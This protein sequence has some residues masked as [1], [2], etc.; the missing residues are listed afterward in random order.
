MEKL[1][2]LSVETNSEREVG[3]DRNEMNLEL[4][5][6]SEEAI[7]LGSRS[8]NR[9]LMYSSGTIS[10]LSWSTMSINTGSNEEES[11]RFSDLPLMH[12]RSCFSGIGD[13]EKST[14][15]HQVYL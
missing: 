4:E 1:L 7:K 13:L 10:E 2:E 14:L 6:N 3:V 15:E 9:S 12:L 8:S 5:T 11:S